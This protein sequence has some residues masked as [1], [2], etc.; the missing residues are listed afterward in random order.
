MCFASDTPK[1]FK[2]KEDESS[3]DTE[4]FKVA[5]SSQSLGDTTSSGSGDSGSSYD[6]TKETSQETSPQNAKRN[7]IPTEVFEEGSQHNYFC[8]IFIT[9]TVCFIILTLLWPYRALDSRTRTTFNFCFPHLF[10]KNRHPG[11]LHS[12]KLAGLFPLKTFKPSLDR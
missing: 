9:L 6:A 5:K 4:N 12:Q 1:I 10:S 3:E 2:P 7:V 11:K 8:Q